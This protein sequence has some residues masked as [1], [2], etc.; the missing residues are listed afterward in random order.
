MKIS[1]SASYFLIILI[2]LA[3]IF[4]F[5]SNK[6]KKEDKILL[7]TLSCQ[8]DK[9]DQSILSLNA[10]T[11]LIGAYINFKKVPI[12]QAEK[13]QLNKLKVMIDEKSWIFER[14]QAQIPTASLC[15]LIQS[16][17]IDYIF[18]PQFN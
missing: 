6:S 17:N 14:A 10:K 13:D 3:L 2:S 11:T 18:I 8:S 12:T 5:V 7:Q 1:Q 16:E 15:D 4:T 9:I